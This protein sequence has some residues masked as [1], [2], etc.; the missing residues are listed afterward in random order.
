MFSQKSLETEF[1][2]Q[3]MAGKLD[4]VQSLARSCPEYWNT[5]PALLIQTAIWQKQP[6][7]VIYLLQQG[8]RITQ[9]DLPVALALLTP[10]DKSEN[11]DLL[12]PSDADLDYVLVGINFAIA[13]EDWQW[14]NNVVNRI[15]ASQK[16][17]A[18]R[19]QVLDIIRPHISQILKCGHVVFAADDYNW[20]LKAVIRARDAD[21]V[22]A[23][24]NCV[25]ASTSMVMP[26]LVA[27]VSLAVDIQTTRCFEKLIPHVA[28]ATLPVEILNQ[29]I[30]RKDIYIIKQLLP[31]CRIDS[32]LDLRPVFGSDYVHIL[33]LF[34][35]AKIDILPYVDMDDCHH[36]W[37]D[38]SQCL[39]YLR[40]MQKRQILRDIMTNM[41]KLVMIMEHD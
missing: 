23:I 10:T 2:G 15:L 13:S 16:P 36:S 40:R 27:A 31:K 12:L 33:R 1:I 7:I 34:N 18:K 26:D 19:D 5:Q 21:A 4:M 30:S 22:D 41:Q 9:A 32:R 20:L 6:A 17:G 24:M 25:S 29:T 35:E 28:D 39:A 38:A 37:P 11:C 8:F 3:I 14:L